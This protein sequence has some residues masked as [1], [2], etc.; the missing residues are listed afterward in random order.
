MEI[1]QLHMLKPSLHR[2]P[3][4]TNFVVPIVFKITPRHGPCRNTPFPTALLLLCVDSLLR[5][6]VYRVV[7]LKNNSF[8]N[9]K[10]FHTSSWYHHISF[11][12]SKLH[13]A[14]TITLC[15][16]EALQLLVQMYF[17]YT[18]HCYNILYFIG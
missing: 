11:T 7:A 16:H 2:L 9:Q 15:Q 1:L 17:H 14:E 6:H 13:I 10:P 3:Y 4:R 18:S 8:I 5:E 12:C